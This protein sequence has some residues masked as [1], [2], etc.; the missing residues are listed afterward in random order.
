M[1]AGGS[2]DSLLVGRLASAH[3]LLGTPGVE[4]KPGVPGPLGAPEVRLGPTSHTPR[5]EACPGLCAAACGNGECCNWQLGGGRGTR[6]L[7]SAISPRGSAKPPIREPCYSL[8]F[9]YRFRLTF[10]L[11]VHQPCPLLLLKT[12]LSFVSPVAIA[13]QV[14]VPARGFPTTSNNQPAPS[15]RRMAARVQSSSRAMGA[16]RP[17]VRTSP[18]C[19]LRCP[20]PCLVTI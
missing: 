6:A 9:E 17:R 14:L 13:V 11:P 8:C 15:F 18:P 2:R 7:R 4:G 5:L 16:L 10:A 20:R 19:L 3:R 1:G 12:D